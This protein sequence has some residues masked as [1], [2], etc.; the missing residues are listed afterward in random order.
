VPGQQVGDESGKLLVL[1][2]CRAVLDQDI[3]PFDVPEL[4]QLTKWADQMGLPSRGKF[5]ECA[6]Q[7]S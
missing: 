6:F 7:R 2:L 3:L 5:R 1:P 4:A